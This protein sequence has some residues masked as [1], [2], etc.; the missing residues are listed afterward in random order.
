MAT[1][2]PPRLKS[3]P[4]KGRVGGV[5]STGELFVFPRVFFSSSLPPCLVICAALMQGI[6]FGGS[7]SINLDPTHS[8]IIHVAFTNLTLLLPRPA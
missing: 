8:A 5:G 7:L 4:E 2:S 3:Q 6:E 1:R